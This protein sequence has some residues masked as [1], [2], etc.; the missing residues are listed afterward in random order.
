LRKVGVPVTATLEVCQKASGDDNSDN[1]DNNNDNNDDLS[2][3][4]ISELSDKEAIA[5]EY[6]SGIN[7][8]TQEK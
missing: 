1:N 6:F 5:E 7:N 2:T 4:G 8:N 3:I